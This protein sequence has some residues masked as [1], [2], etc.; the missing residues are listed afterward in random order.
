MDP[1]TSAIAFAQAAGACYKSVTLFRRASL[2]YQSSSQFANDSP[3]SRLA[4][5]LI[6]KYQAYKHANERIENLVVKIEGIWLKTRTQLEFLQSIVESI[7]KEL[8]N[9]QNKCLERLNKELSLAILDIE[10]LTNTE[11]ESISLRSLSLSVKPLKKAHY[12]VIEKSLR[13]RV[14]ELNSWHKDF[15][16][17]WFLIGRKADTGIDNILKNQSRDADTQE[18]VLNVIS[19]IREAISAT[20]TGASSRASVFLESST[21]SAVS[22]PLPNSTVSLCSLKTDSTPVLLDMTTFDEDVDKGKYTTHVRDLAKLLSLS[23]P[24]TLGLLK[25]LGVIKIFESSGSLL[26]FQFIYQI[27]ST[28]NKAS[29][30]RTQLMGSPISLDARFRLSRSMARNLMAVHS[31]DLVHKNIRP[32]TIVVFEDSSDPLPVSFL[33]GFERFRPFKAGTSLTG[34]MVW[35][36]NIY[37]HPKRQGI[38]PEDEYI[39]QHDIYSLGVCL[40][41]IGL[42]T[43]FVATAEQRLDSSKYTTMIERMRAGIAGEIKNIFIDMAL[44][45]LPFAMGRVYTEVVLSCLTCLDQG[46]SNM[47]ANVRELYDED[48]ILVGVAFIEKILMRLES[49]SL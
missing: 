38:K 43:S 7:D 44:E 40:L 33:L 18:G 39:M 32:E 23:K 28:L 41:E 30:L 35:E 13:R 21:L 17:S 34:D 4:T 14:D 19:V 2:S 12:A 45:N 48:G 20:R 9:Y 37:R 15:D 47:F 24:D 27:P 25:C 11:F 26:Q 29:S 36:R 42:W 49:I 3:L 31:A 5:S 1:V 8:L 16:P 22:T 46:A 6:T 10:S